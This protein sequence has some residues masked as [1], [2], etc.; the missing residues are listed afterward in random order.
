MSMSIVHDHCSRQYQ[1]QVVMKVSQRGRLYVDH[2][3]SELTGESS[4]AHP[5]NS[6]EHHILAGIHSS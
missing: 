3:I 4:F 2:L 5:R 1:K 6:N